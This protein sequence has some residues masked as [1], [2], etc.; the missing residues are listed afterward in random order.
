MTARAGPPATTPR[1]TFRY[2]T[3]AEVICAGPD[4][5][6]AVLASGIGRPA[7]FCSSACRLRA[8]RARQQ[9]ERQPVTV[10]VDFGSASSRGRSPDRAWMVRIRRGQRSVIVS[11]G[12]RLHAA[13]SLA[14]QIA[15]VLGAPTPSRPS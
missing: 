14:E 4:C 6:E 12:L 5:T 1:G 13:I 7:R 2:D 9:G 10:E 11:I 15:D 8:H 3:K